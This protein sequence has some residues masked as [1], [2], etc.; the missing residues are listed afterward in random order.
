[1]KLRPVRM[2]IDTYH[3]LVLYMRRDCPIC[4]S[5]G[6]TASTRLLVSSADRQVIARDEVFG[7]IRPAALQI[8]TTIG[9]VRLP[10]RPPMQCLS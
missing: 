9:V 10:G 8:A 4:L 7:R 2:G 6:F 3:E 5:E 1:M